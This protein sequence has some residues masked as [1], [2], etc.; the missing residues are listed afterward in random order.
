ML[1]KLIKIE[2]R[3]GPA[4]ILPHYNTP[5]YVTQLAQILWAN[6]FVK[7]IKKEGK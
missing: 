1:N 5:Y 7:P 4:W 2:T 6:R 3:N